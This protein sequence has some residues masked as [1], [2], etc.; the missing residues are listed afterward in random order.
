MFI[1]SHKDTVE[2]IRFQN[3]WQIEEVN[4]KTR[5]VA[6]LQNWEK[7]AGNDNI[8]QEK[9]QRRNEK[10][11]RIEKWNTIKPTSINII[12]RYINIILEC[13][14]SYHLQKERQRLSLSDAIG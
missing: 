3:N 12:R 14:A 5:V 10:P 13:E 4:N 7:I 6:S 11:N 1:S 2:E 9:G 8:A